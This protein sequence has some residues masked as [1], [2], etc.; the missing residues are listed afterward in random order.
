MAWAFQPEREDQSVAGNLRQ[1]C[2][3]GWQWW[4]EPRSVVRG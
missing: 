1:D 4:G 2:F 3:S